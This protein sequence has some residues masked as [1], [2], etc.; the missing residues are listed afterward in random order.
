MEWWKYITTKTQPTPQP[1]QPTSPPYQTQPISSQSINP[2]PQPIPPQPINTIPQPIPSHSIQPTQPT[3]QPYISPQSPATAHYISLA[4][5]QKYKNEMESRIEDLEER[6][7]SLEG[8]EDKTNKHETL[9]LKLTI[10][11]DIIHI[12]GYDACQKIKD[13]FLKSTGFTYIWGHKLGTGWVAN[14]D[15]LKIFK[16]NIELYNNRADVKI[17]IV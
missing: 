3:Y 1:T 16:N 11:E 5:F 17:E 13:V 8:E 4:E 12:R 9:K 7:K 15:K 2:N 14:R 6:I 10:L